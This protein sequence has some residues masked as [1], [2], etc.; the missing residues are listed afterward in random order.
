[1][2][3]NLEAGTNTN[4]DFKVADGQPL[5]EPI[6]LNVRR[7]LEVGRIVNRIT[8]FKASAGILLRSD[9]ASNLA[10]VLEGINMVEEN[11]KKIKPLGQK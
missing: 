2:S 4:V 11:L 3:Q 6:K 5:V 9:S 10:A 7:S 1:M 8:F